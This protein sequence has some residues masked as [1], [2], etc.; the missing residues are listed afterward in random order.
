MWCSA[1]FGGIGFLM[2]LEYM[3]LTMTTVPTSQEKEEEEEEA[4][5]Q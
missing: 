2:R 1:P 4:G 5:R 3:C